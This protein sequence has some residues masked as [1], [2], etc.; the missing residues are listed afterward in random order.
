MKPVLSG[1]LLQLVVSLL[2]LDKLEGFFCL[3]LNDI[4]VRILLEVS[5]LNPPFQKNNS[6]MRSV[7]MFWYITKRS[8]HPSPKNMLRF[9][10]VM[11]GILHWTAAKETT[12]GIKVSVV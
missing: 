2:I 3:L 7:P 4:F 5:Y 6:C 9:M 10:E 11:S 1:P 12:M 8:T